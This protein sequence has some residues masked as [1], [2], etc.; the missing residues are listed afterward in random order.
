METT[1]M[2]NRRNKHFKYY[3]IW[4]GVYRDESTGQANE[5]FVGMQYGRIGSEG[6]TLFKSFTGPYCHTDAWAFL[7]GKISEKL[8]EGYQV[9]E[10]REIK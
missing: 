4:G 10:E 3:K 2:E 1:Y 5:A 9:C 6:R 7:N 8:A